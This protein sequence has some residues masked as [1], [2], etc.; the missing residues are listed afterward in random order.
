V[1]VFTYAERR[2]AGRTSVYEIGKVQ[3]RYRSLRRRLYEVGDA[4]TQGGP[5]KQRFAPVLVGQ[6]R[7]E[8]DPRERQELVDGLDL[9]GQRDGFGG[10]TGGNFAVD[11]L[12]DQV[13]DV[14]RVEAQRHAVQPV[15]KYRPVKG[16]RAVGAG[17]R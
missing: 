9:P 3:H 2:H 8:S 11:D 16:R 7:Q 12:T 5:G 13:L 10:R 4:E 1:L 6:R 14:D 15:G 17:N